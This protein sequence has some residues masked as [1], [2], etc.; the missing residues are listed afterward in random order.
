MLRIWHLTIYSLINIKIK[1]YK[2]TMVQIISNWWRYPDT[3]EQHSHLNLKIDLRLILT[4]IE[5][6]TKW[7]VTK[8]S[9]TLQ[10]MRI[11]TM[12]N[13]G[14]HRIISMII[15]LLCLSFSSLDL[16]LAT[17]GLLQE[18]RPARRRIREEHNLCLVLITR[19]Q[20][21]KMKL[22]KMI[23][24]HYHKWG[25]LD[26]HIRICGSL[27]VLQ[28]GQTGL[29]RWWWWLLI[30]K[31]DASVVIDL[32]AWNILDRKLTSKNLYRE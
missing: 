1:R 6:K 10:F 31:E 23:I 5:I 18:E 9:Q 12:T 20:Y 29:I 15:N 22:I 7:I 19:I 26:Q 32:T 3:Q 28:K 17:N 21:L 14:D 27:G 24:E 8:E 2:P 11:F 25:N 16:T 4:L 13:F 30:R